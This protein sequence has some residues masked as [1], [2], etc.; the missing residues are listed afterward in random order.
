MS[1]KAPVIAPAGG[2]QARSRTAKKE[3][4]SAPK[5]PEREVSSQPLGALSITIYATANWPG[6]GGATLQIFAVPPRLGRFSVWDPVGEN[7][8]LL[9]NPQYSHST[10][11]S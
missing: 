8:E 10:E 11:A 3:P 6:E 7:P 9:V 1:R 5:T 4:D 2:F